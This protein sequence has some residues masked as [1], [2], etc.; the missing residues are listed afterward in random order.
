MKKYR[1]LV[2]LFTMLWV[3]SSAMTLENTKT[4]S[5]SWAVSEIQTLNI[6]NKFGEVRVE[7]S[8]GSQ[9]TVD[10]KV[11]VDGY[12]RRNEEILNGISVNFSKSGSSASAETK[13]ANNLNTNGNGRMSVD[14]VINI[15]EDKNLNINNKFGNVIIRTLTGKGNLTVAY[16]SLTAGKLI[17]PDNQDMLGIIRR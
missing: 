2:V 11:T 9:I 6:S 13:F 15:P 14:Y 3:T 8:N 7:N 17:A 12:G 4:Y 10:V 5:H 16:G 1:F